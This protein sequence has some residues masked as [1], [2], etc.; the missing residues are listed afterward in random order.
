MLVDILRARRTRNSPNWL[1]L[2]VCAL[3]P[4]IGLHW[5]STVLVF[6][7]IRRSHGGLGA[8]VFIFLAWDFL[9]E[10]SPSFPVNRRLQESAAAFLF[11]CTI[12]E[13]KVSC[14]SPE[15]RTLL[16]TVF[17]CNPTLKGNHVKLLKETYAERNTWAAIVVDLP[18]CH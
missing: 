1:Q 12:V 3:A 8:S 14:F 11:H 13:M 6:L 9:L 2:S 5:N 18:K 7:Q 4:P 10:K 17:L 16:I 15:T